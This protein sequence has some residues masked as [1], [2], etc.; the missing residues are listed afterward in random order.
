MNMNA[1]EIAWEMI[2]YTEFRI[3]YHIR[4][5]GDCIGSAYALG[6]A[7]QSVG[8]RCEVIG[9]Y[10]V[11]AQ[12]RYLTDV[13]RSDP[14]TD[15]VWVSVDSAGPD[16]AGCYGGEHFTF[17]IDHHR[18]NSIEADFKCVEE[19]CGACS[20]II[21]KVIRG[22]GAQV[23]KSVADLLYMALVSDTMS[24]R[25]A[26]T[27]AQ[28]FETA[29][30]LYRCGADVYRI[31]RNHTFYKSAGRMRIEQLLTES[32]HYTC[33]GRILTGII[34]QADLQAAGIEDSALEGINCFMERI[35]GVRI[36]GTIRELADGKIRVSVHTNGNISA[37][38]IVR[39][40]GG[41][42]HF[43]AAGC[44][45]PDRTAG[46]VRGMLEETCRRHLEEETT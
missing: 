16:R 30:E 9:E 31:G 2:N 13:F 8:K 15:P 11:P 17:C 46:E 27:D 6:L 22:I 21:L 38:A 28:T 44:V 1:Q 3:V 29:A 42:G 14:L 26:D 45:I 40:F 12:H 32:F 7:L 10:P 4:P 35:E 43:H 20:E 36:S 25:T 37:D 33:E 18:G 39:E 19:D 34:T 24:F 41:A 23:T 5:D